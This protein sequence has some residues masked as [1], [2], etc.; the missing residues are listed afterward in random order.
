M[1][2]ISGQLCDLCGTCIA[3]CPEDALVMTPVLQCDRKKCTRCGR[4]VGICP[5]GALSI[6]QE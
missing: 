4:C 6:D 2:K 3:V 1:V 5:V